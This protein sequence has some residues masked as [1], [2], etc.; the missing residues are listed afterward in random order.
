MDYREIVKKVVMRFGHDK[1]REDREDFQQECEVAILEEQETIDKLSEKDR[2]KYV[3]IICKNRLINILKKTKPTLSLTTE[4]VLWEAEKTE[5][6][7]QNVDEVVDAEA[8]IEYLNRLPEPYSTIIA[9][10]FGIDCD[11]RTQEE[12]AARFCKTQQWVQKQEQI[13]LDRLREIMKCR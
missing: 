8:V 7:V 12:I 10:R 9:L 2:E 5:A 6:K 11:P 4:E 1:S 13:A 3:Y